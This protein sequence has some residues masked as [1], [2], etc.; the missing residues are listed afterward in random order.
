MLFGPHDDDE[1]N[2][3]GAMHAYVCGFIDERISQ[4]PMY[5]L[6]MEFS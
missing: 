2:I 6:P 1:P 5:V 4:G 3:P